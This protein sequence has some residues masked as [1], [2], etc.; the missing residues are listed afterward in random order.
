MINIKNFEEK[1][2]AVTI[3]LT[4]EQADYLTGLL[5]NLNYS[6][7]AEQVMGAMAF[8]NEIQTRLTV[9]MKPDK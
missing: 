1:Q 7:N 9:A 4:R 5:K 8:V 2:A 3:T 6:G